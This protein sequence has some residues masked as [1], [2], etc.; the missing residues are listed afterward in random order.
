MRI[1]ILLPLP[2]ASNFVGDS[3]AVSDLAGDQIIPVSV[4]IAP[5]STTNAHGITTRSKVGILK[6]KAYLAGIS[7]PSTATSALK[8]P[9]W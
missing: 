5:A 3:L 4:P 2:N 1:V 6:P 8:Q 9:H 7:T